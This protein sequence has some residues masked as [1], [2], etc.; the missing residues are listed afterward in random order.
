MEGKN[1]PSFR[2]SH[3]LMLKTAFRHFF[4]G[5]ALLKT[6][7]CYSCI[8]LEMSLTLLDNPSVKYLLITFT[9]FW[10]GP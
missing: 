6:Q 8:A 5:K 1:I 7:L 10:G 2:H 3:L 4:L 9:P